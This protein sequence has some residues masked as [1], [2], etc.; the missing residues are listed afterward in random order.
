MR[1]AQWRKDGR[2]HSRPADPERQILL[3]VLRP[4][5]FP[6]LQMQR[7]YP[8]IGLKAAQAASSRMLKKSTSF[9]LA[10]FRS[11]TYPRGYASCLH[12]LRPRWTAFLSILRI[13][14]LLCYTCGQL[15][16]HCVMIVFP[17][18]ASRLK[19]VENRV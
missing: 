7:W 14:L 6:P 13:V 5:A 1:Q 17:Q 9:V 18:S 16:F 12:S 19:L 3:P 11:S 8:T 10:S 15:S 2:A 4:Q